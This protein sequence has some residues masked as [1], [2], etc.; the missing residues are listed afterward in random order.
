MVGH[1]SGAILRQLK[2][3]LGAG[4]FSGLSDRQLLERFLERRDE[5]AEL[6]F[7]V[8]VERHGRMVLGVCRR[9]MGGPDEADDAFQAT[10]LVLA[11]R[12]RS[13]RVEGTLGPWL[14][15]VATRVAMRA[16][17]DE[18]RRRARERNGLDRLERPGPDAAREDLDRAEIQEIIAREVAG[19]PARFQGPVLLCDLEG[20][21]YQEAA[22]RL[23]WPVGTVRSRLSRAR[24]RLRRRLA[25]YGLSPAAD[26]SI[27][28]PLLVAAPSP[29]LVGATTRA[30]MV[31]TSP[32]PAA[33]GIVP[34]SVAT[35]TQGV[36]RTMIST[37]LKLAAGVLLTVA[38]GS[39]ILLGQA[40]AQKAGGRT[41][42]PPPAMASAGAKAAPAN[43]DRVDI[44][45]L[46]RAWADAIARRD[47]SVI[48]RIL[49]DDFEGIDPSAATF[50]KSTYLAHLESGT[51]GGAPIDLEDIRARLYGDTAVAVI[52]TR[53]R[54]SGS[55]ARTTKVY[56]KRRGRWQCVASHAGVHGA[57][58][59]ESAK[60]AWWKALQG[61][62]NTLSRK[63]FDTWSCTSCHTTHVHPD[64]PLRQA[65]GGSSPHHYGHIASIN[66]PF[67]CLVEKVRV[68]VGQ[69]VRKGDPLIGLVCPELDAARIG[70]EV[71]LIHGLPGREIEINQDKGGVVTVR[72]TLCSEVDGTILAVV[73]KPG[74]LYDRKDVLIKIGATPTFDDRRSPAGPQPTGPTP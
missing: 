65:E 51:L 19:L 25:R 58:S 55:Y 49:A 17:S 46:E 24:A 12:A 1:G 66:A 64:P 50:T 44:E 31:L 6:A 52:Q 45:M 7:A 27:A 16:R 13:I 37:R 18:R 69:H 39:A 10:F 35:L 56:T 41:V 57:V 11:R 29:G 4:T 36:L 32:E 60:A 33:A 63:A 22:R 59:G 23:G 74:S 61:G 70:D 15:G 38:T 5:G 26:L 28:P 72:F 47:A 53:I 2:S 34:A 21:S 48:N 42:D 43:D 8:L 73:A 30:A 14:F 3:L 62:D 68:S 9:I 67:K 20:M 40:S 71:T 54:S